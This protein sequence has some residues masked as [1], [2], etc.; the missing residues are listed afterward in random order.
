MDLFDISSL[1]LPLTGQETPNTKHVSADQDFLPSP[2][3]TPEANQCFGLEGL[4]SLT[5][6]LS[7]GANEQL[8]STLSPSSIG[9]DLLSQASRQDN[10]PADTSDSFLFLQYIDDLNTGCTI[11]LEYMP[12]FDDAL[13][14]LTTCQVG[15]S[16]PSQDRTFMHRAAEQADPSTLDACFSNLNAANRSTGIRGP[17]YSSHNSSLPLDIVPTTEAMEL[18][19]EWMTGGDMHLF[20][21]KQEFQSEIGALHAKIKDLEA[22]HAEIRAELAAAQRAFTDW[23]VEAKR[24][25]EKMMEAVGLRNS[26]IERE[27][28]RE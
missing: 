15:Q 13:Y 25:Y 24:S 1:E 27:L 11:D 10:E 5:H 20:C 23:T 14:G 28:E 18:D 16:P 17:S 2:Q 19:F 6:T 7:H 12:Q 22:S 3:P 9:F 21:E 4:S 8:T 26:V